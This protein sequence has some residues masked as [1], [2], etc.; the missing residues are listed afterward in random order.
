MENTRNALLELMPCLNCIHCKNPLVDPHIL[1]LCGHVACSSCITSDKK[2]SACETPTTTQ[3]IR[4]DHQMKA[5]VNCALQLKEL[6]FTKDIS[7]TDNETSSS[8]KDAESCSPKRSNRDIEAN[9]TGDDTHAEEQPAGKSSK[10]KQ[11]ASKVNPD[12]D[13]SF[14][15]VSSSASKK[16]LEKR[17]KLGETVLHAATVKCQLD[18][19]KKLLEAGANPNVHDNA[20]WTPLH[21]ACGHGNLE[22][23]HLLIAH[24]AQVNVA[25]GDGVTPLHDAVMSS[26][27]DVVLLLMRS[28]ADVS[29]RTKDG[30][31]PLDL[32]QNEI[33]RAA[34]ST[35]PCMPTAGANTNTAIKE[36]PTNRVVLLGSG[37]DERQEQDLRRCVEILGADLKTTFSRDVTHLVVS[38]NREGN[39]QQRT[40]KVLSALVTGKWI[41]STSWVD[42]C[43]RKTQRVSEGPYE[44]KGTRQHPNSEAPR[45]SRE[46]FAS[47]T[48]PS[49]LFSGLSICLQGPLDAPPKEE[50]SALL[51]L[52]GATVL[53][54]VPPS[55]ETRVVVVTQRFGADASQRG[56]HV[57][58]V[59]PS[60]V[61][62]CVSKFEVLDPAEYVNTLE[63]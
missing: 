16:H 59:P 30:R 61:L 37:L 22:L 12:Q 34:L 13:S 33:M 19:V 46:H 11:V 44:A 43:L 48:Y 31:T 24:G 14:A 53:P 55:L 29:A 41:V 9:K 45:K 58:T 27:P 23:V 38:C 35:V 21:E 8:H 51:A 49:G 57:V 54:R 3:E 2:C 5:V 10:R 40:L 17:N 18:R 6:L 36:R 7:P 39:C 52:G 15:S 56:G 60:W 50:L 47:S 42:E 28:G 25:T 63:A 4:P 20:G 1:G 62:D 32:A 26:Q